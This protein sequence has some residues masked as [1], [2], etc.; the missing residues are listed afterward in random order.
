[1][2]NL[3]SVI[4]RFA[5]Q[6]MVY[7]EYVGPDEYGHPYYKDPVELKVR[8]EGRREEVVSS[9]GRTVYTRAYI[10]TYVKVVEGSLVMLGTLTDFQAM[11]CYPQE[12]TI[13]FNVAEIL[14]VKE[15]PDIKARSN[16]YEAFA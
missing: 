1:M 12:P 16:V 3:T 4:K 14:T 2:P 15:T 7:W 11:D 9:D 6:T 10:L 5:R 8:W 13:Q